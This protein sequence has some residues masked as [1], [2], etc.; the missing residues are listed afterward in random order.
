MGHVAC[1]VTLLHYYPFLKN[2]TM[3]LKKQFSEVIQIIKKAQANAYK[4][5]N[6]ELI[7]CY[8]QVGEY[9]SKRVAGAVWGDKTINN[10]A[11]FIKKNCMYLPNIKL[12]PII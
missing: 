9:I 2:I 1:Y 5:V 12:F 3:S 6:I 4:I 8:W 10:P 11:V 7:N